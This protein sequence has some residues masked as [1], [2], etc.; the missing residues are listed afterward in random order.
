MF[1]N[2]CMDGPHP[3]GIYKFQILLYNKCPVSMVGSLGSIDAMYT[4]ALISSN[5]FCNG[6]TLKFL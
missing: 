1:V 5:T 3:F 2:I 4:P 6:S